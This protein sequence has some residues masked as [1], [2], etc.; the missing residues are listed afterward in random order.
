M[1]VVELSQVVRNSK[2]SK[3]NQNLWS[4]KTNRDDTKL[5]V[6]DELKPSP[7]WCSQDVQIIL[8]DCHHGSKNIKMPPMSKP[9]I[10]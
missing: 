1:F 6:L 5:L 8:I 4:T 10:K 9:E 2:Y 7:S 3:H